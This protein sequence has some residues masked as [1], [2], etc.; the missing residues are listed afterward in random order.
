MPS[1]F[2]FLLSPACWRRRNSG[3][4]A[5]HTGTVVDDQGRPVPGATVGCYHYQSRAGFGYWDREPKLEQTTVT[6]DKGAFAVSASAY[7]TLVVVKKASFS[8]AWKTWSALIPVSTDPIVLTAPAALSGVVVNDSGQP[9]ADAEVW[10]AGANIGN[11]YDV[12]SQYNELF[13]GPAKSFFSARTGADGRFR[14]ENFPADG[15]AGLA[16]HKAGMAR[17]TVGSELGGERDCQPGQDL[18]LV[19]GPAGNVE[20]KVLVA[21]T[22]Q[23][24]GGVKIQMDQFGAGVFG[25]DYYEAVETR[26]DGTFRVAD[27]QPGKHCIRA[28]IS[29]GPIP[30]WVL[31]PEESQILTVTAGE[32][33]SNVVIHFSKGALVEVKV[34]VTNTLQALANVTVSSGEDT[35]YTDDNGVAFVRSLTGTNGFSAAKQDWS[36]RQTTAVVESSRTNQVRIEMVPPPHITG[37]V[38]DSSGVP[39]PGVRVSFHPG[40]RPMAPLYSETTADE[41]G[42]YEMTITQDSR[43]F[44]F[45]SGPV[46]NTDFILARDLDR[47]LA[48]IRD[49]GSTNSDPFNQKIEPL[50]TNIDLILQPG[51]TISGSVRDTD[52]SPVTNATVDISMLSS[53]FIVNLWPQ[54]AK[55]D[56]QGMFTLP[57]LPQGREYEFWQ[58]IKAKGYGTAYARVEA[59]DT[60]T[61]HYEFPAFVLKRA[62]RKLAGQDSGP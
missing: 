10:V 4:T 32:T 38:R 17:H 47:N 49:F 20:G 40:R 44:G 41:N 19:V 11:G 55:V 2:F 45:W 51:I 12:A 22:G 34:I 30:D 5:Q 28:G 13:G 7:S 26:A 25:S 56:A 58:G 52:G 60:E 42:R 16:V 37:I 21:D 29:G 35:A 33:V 53:H 59:K 57:A 1:Q 9:V 36:P 6:D 62:D 31:V 50:P 27:V 54:P 46:N 43:G 18:K 24:L 23:P 15:R 61:N 39:A 3:T 48:T 8:T 14:I